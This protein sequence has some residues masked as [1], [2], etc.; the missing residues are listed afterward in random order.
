MSLQHP[1]LKGLW[2]EVN[3]DLNGNIWHE[4]LRLLPETKDFGTKISYSQ[5]NVLSILVFGS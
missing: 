4:L 1:F 5:R 2:I 3:T